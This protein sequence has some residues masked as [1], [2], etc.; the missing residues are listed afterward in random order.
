MSGLAVRVI[1]AASLF[2]LWLAP[3]PEPAYACSCP[4]VD[5]L[6]VKVEGYPV[7]FKGRVVWTNADDT[8]FS[9][10]IQVKLA[11]ETVWKGDVTDP[12]NV[13]TGGHDGTCPFLFRMD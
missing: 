9:W 7:V 13:T 4:S 12:I 1:L 5:P 11:V 2:G 6:S 8:D 10:P 3:Q